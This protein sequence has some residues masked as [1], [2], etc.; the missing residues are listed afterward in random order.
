MKELF[1]QEER[2]EGCVIEGKS[3]TKRKQLD[4]ERVELLKGI[5]R[6]LINNYT[7]FIY[8]LYYI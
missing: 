4:P 6:V 2:S 8:N 7:I 5:V 3:T 1:T